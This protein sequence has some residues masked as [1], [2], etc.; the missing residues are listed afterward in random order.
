MVLEPLLFLLNL[1]W[2]QLKA[3]RARDAERGSVTLEQVIIAGG[4]AVVALAVIG[5]IYK[6]VT[7]KANTIPTDAP[8]G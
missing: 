7:D 1:K 3:V 4:L 6:K 2:G 8:A 5:I